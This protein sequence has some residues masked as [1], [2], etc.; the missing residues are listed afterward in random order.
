MKRLLFGG[1]IAL[2]LLRLSYAEPLCK[3][4]LDCLVKYVKNG[5]VRYLEYGC[6]NYKDRSFG[7]SCKKLY[8][9]FLNKMGR[10]VIYLCD[11]GNSAA[12]Q[13]KILYNFDGGFRDKTSAAKEVAE[14][15]KQS[16]QRCENKVDIMECISAY[17]VYKL[18]GNS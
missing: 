1:F 9:I 7:H 8:Q 5:D 6:D 14:T 16:E 10:D 11:K 18:L 15:L 3:D 13:Y 17:N 12:C 2:S 4:D